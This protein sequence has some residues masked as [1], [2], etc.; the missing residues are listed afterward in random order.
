MDCL[1]ADLRIP[2]ICRIFCSLDQIKYKTSRPFSGLDNSCATPFIRF[3]SCNFFRAFQQ[4]FVGIRITRIGVQDFEFFIF[5]TRFL[6]IGSDLGLTRLIILQISNKY[7]CNNNEY[8][9]ARLVLRG[10]IVGR[11]Y[12]HSTGIFFDESNDAVLNIKVHR[13]VRGI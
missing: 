4:Q 2:H 10:R 6:F 12:F 5:E 13:H 7:I 3:N 9:I 1:Q 11:F 8:S